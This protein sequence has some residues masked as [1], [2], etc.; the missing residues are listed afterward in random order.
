MQT[1]RHTISSR[2]RADV[3]RLRPLAGSAPLG[4]SAFVAHGDAS[5]PGLRLR[6]DDVLCVSSELGE[7][8]LQVLA[9]PSAGHPMLGH[10]RRGQLRSLPADLPCSEDFWGPVGSVRAVWRRELSASLPASLGA[11]SAPDAEA[12]ARSRALCV[13][14]PQAALALVRAERPEL[15]GA[16]LQAAP[17]P[18]G[19]VLV[20]PGSDR[21][22]AP[23]AQANARQLQGLADRLV[24]ALGMGAEI[25]AVSAAEVVVGVRRAIDLPEASLLSR[26]LMRQLR[27]PLAV[28]V[29][30]QFPQAL[31]AVRS[32]GG[33]Q[34]LFLL[35]EPTQAQAAAA[36]APRAV[37]AP[38]PAAPAPA[39]RPTLLPSPPAPRLREQPRARPAQGA[40]QLALFERA[41]A[42]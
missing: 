36:R 8:G 24:L 3:F 39:P 25:L 21:A 29:A 1:Q 10:R 26:A 15:M 38:R 32:L 7:G 9:P 5:L 4:D 12:P 14:V 22:A 16:P 27:L 20:F 6:N 18:G 40:V 11:A 30:E 17:Q 35:P 41:E 28:A 33:D 2:R 42:A 19:T 13:R 23:V 37:V 34:L 31:E